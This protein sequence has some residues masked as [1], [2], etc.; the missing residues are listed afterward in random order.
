VKDKKERKKLNKGSKFIIVT[1]LIASLL[2]AAA[3]IYRMARGED[4][5]LSS[6]LRVEM[7]YVIVGLLATVAALLLTLFAGYLYERFSKNNT[8]RMTQDASR[9]FLQ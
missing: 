8:H 7:M 1:V 2:L 5:F 6:G 3:V 4:L 9:H